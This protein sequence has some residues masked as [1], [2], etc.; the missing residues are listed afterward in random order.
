MGVNQIYVQVPFNNVSTGS[1]VQLA[2]IQG[3]FRRNF[4][5]RCNLENLG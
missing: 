1:K 5:F 4:W 2:I 3:M